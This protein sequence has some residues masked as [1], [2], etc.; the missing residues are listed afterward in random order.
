[1][2]K[3]RWLMLMT[4]HPSQKEPDHRQECMIPT[5]SDPLLPFRP[6]RIISEKPHHWLKGLLTSRLSVKP[7]F[8]YGLPTRIG[9]SFSSTLMKHTRTWWKN[10]MLMPLLK[11][12]NSN[13]GL[14]ER[15]FQCLLFIW[16]KSYTSTDQCLLQHWC[17]MICIRT[18]IYFGTLLEETWNSHKLGT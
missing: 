7:T 17:M 11:E 14:E 13:S 10:S 16:Q 15:F 1:M 18:R 12:M 2:E 5:S 4:A 6:M 3:S 9:T 8:P